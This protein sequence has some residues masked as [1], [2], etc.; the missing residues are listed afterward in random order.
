MR[1]YFLSCLILFGRY[2][3]LEDH[4]ERGATVLPVRQRN[5]AQQA[6]WYILMHQSTKDSLARYTATATKHERA[7]KQWTPSLV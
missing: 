7:R 2:C 4:E 1:E 6:T 3:V 5:E